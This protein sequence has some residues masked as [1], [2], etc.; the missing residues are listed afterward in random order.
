MMHAAHANLCLFAGGD[1]ETQIAAATEE[2][3]PDLHI[4]VASGSPT[5]LAR[6]VASAL[7]RQG[8]NVR[9]IAP[10]ESLAGAWLRVRSTH[11]VDV[12]VGSRASRLT[13]VTLPDALATA[14]CVV[15]VNT[16]TLEDAAGDPIAIGLWAQFAHP[17]QRT[18]AR[19]SDPRDGLT[20]EIALAVKPRLTLLFAIWRDIPLLIATTD[21]IAA[22]LAGLA[23]RQL[24]ND[25]GA[26]VVGPWEHPLVQRATE[27]DLGVA[28]PGQI[29]PVMHWLGTEVDQSEVELRAFAVDFFGRIGVVFGS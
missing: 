20:A 27:L 18:G 3:P 29:I 19:L 24:L 13:R 21:Q 1:P 9:L 12:D 5:E 16:I 7:Q 8:R 2:L 28:M 6:Q 22:E 4:V 14:F 15:A 26:D 23:L 25:V 17:R 10:I 11:W